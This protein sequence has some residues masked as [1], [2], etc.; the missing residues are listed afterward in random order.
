MALISNV[1]LWNSVRNGYPTFASHTSEGTKELFTEAGFQ[2][3]KQYDPTALNDFYDLSLRVYLLTVDIAQVKDDFLDRD[4][5]EVYEQARGGYIQ[6]MAIAPIKPVT[7]AFRGLQNGD[8]PDPFIVRKGKAT[9]RFFKQNFDFQNLLTMPSEELYK[10]MFISEYGMSEYYAGMIL[11]L[12]NSYIVQ[13]YLNKLE[14]IN[15]GINSTQFPLRATQQVAVPLTKADPT[16]D[17]L[18]SLILAIKSMVSAMGVGASVSQFNAAGYPTVQKRD[19]LR[20]LL[21]AD[22]ENQISVKV[23]TSAFNRD[24]LNIP[25]EI[26]PVNNFG[27]L[28]PYMDNDYSTQLYEVYDQKLGYLIG[29]SETEGATTPTIKL[30]DYGNP[31]TE[32]YWKD[33]NSDVIGVLADKGWLFETVQN[34]YRVDTIWNPRGLYMNHWASLV[35]GGIFIDS[36][37]NVV[38]FRAQDRAL[39]GS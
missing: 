12:N 18:T 17:Q 13:R 7:P 39:S 9:E 16:A 38:V 3:L 8:S 33:P 28:I 37:Y 14:A 31:D 20:L 21:K 35:G 23:L 5:G 30:D 36:L 10:N 22:L 29:Y 34:N 2:Q 24:E 6:R 26:I 19:R 1:D 32:I 11:Q 25:V 27:G 15:A 4:F